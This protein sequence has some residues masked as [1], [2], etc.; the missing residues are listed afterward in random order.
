MKILVCI[1]QVPAL[2]NED[3]DKNT[4][5]IIRTG[6]MILNAYDLFAI[7]A[8]LRLKDKYAVE[9]DVITMGPA[10]AKAVIRDAYAYG[11]DCGYLLSDKAFAGADV[12][13]TSYALFQGIKI[14]DEYDL[15]ICGKN[16]TD[17]DTGMVGS[18]LAKWLEIPYIP[19]INQ[20]VIEETG[21]MVTAVRENHNAVIRLYNKC[22]ITVEQKAYW[23]R[24][25]NLKLKIASRKKDIR[26]LVLDDLED[27]D[28]THYG[29]KGSATRVK[30]VYAPVNNSQSQIMIGDNDDVIDRIAEVIK[31]SV[32]WSKQ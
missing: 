6:E 16:T 30:K 18:S 17:G 12:L 27:R 8:A 2:N 24:V 28:P 31:R 14:L 10:S 11:V 3:A 29:M 22:V 21:L 20:I 4:G 19:N 26:H 5:L 1:K 15:I 7:E 25:Q 13:A 23:P 9:V 32:E